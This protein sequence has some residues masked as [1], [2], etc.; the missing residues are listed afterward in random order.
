MNLF[1]EN[2]PV[3]L[4]EILDH[5]FQFHLLTG[6]DGHQDLHRALQ[7]QQQTTLAVTQQL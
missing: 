1:T 3:F 5:R 2:G 7:L 6:I 4:F